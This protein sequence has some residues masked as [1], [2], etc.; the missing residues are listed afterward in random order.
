MDARVAVERNQDAVPRR[1]R[2]EARLDDGDRVD[3]GL[4]RGRWRA[5]AAAA[6][7]AP[8]R[9]TAGHRRHDLHVAPAGRHGKYATIE[10]GREAILRSGAEIVTVALRRVD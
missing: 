6:P 4:R 1:T 9:A 10:Q 7:T 2:A 5:P 8:P 3:R